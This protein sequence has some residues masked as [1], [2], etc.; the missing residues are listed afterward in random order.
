MFPYFPSL[1]I[2]M[3]EIVLYNLTLVQLYRSTVNKNARNLLQLAR[4]FGIISVKN[5]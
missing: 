1:A 5:F 4:K 3:A 2:S